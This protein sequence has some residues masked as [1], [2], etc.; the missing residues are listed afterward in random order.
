M[1][2][3]EPL[4][5]CCN[6]ELRGRPGSLH[7]WALGQCLDLTSTACFSIWCVGV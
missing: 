2:V 5:I 3:N 1:P 6:Q 7:H 4:F